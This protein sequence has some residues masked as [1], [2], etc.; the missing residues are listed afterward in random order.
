MDKI[1]SVRVARP[2]LARPVTQAPRRSHHLSPP[3]DPA[4]RRIRNTLPA[5][6]RHAS[7]L[8]LSGVQ[9][10]TA[11]RSVRRSGIIGH[12][13]SAPHSTLRVPRFPS[14]TICKG[15]V[16]P[17]PRSSPPH[18]LPTAQCLL[19]MHFVAIRFPALSYRFWAEFLDV[20][21]CF[22]WKILHVF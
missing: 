11:Q 22:L 19:L 9:H 14:P 21:I 13:Q 17:P 3:S 5:F 6:H 7:S 16:I 10:R 12:Y 1:T 18:R 8:P 15:S 4:S 20:K 2:K